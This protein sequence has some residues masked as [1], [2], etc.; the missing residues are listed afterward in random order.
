[1]VPALID[2]IKSHG[3]ALVIDRSGEDLS[4]SS[5]SLC[6]A[7]GMHQYHHQQQQNQLGVPST[8]TV[9]PFASVSSGTGTVG[10]MG[11]MKLPKGVDGIL[12]S[13]GVLRFT[14]SI[15]A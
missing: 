10:S 15:D 13:N 8:V 12:R 1:M 5:S 14:E 3:L 6:S 7:G 2:A 9:D 4:S 11:M